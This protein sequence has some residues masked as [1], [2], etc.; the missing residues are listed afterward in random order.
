MAVA[1]AAVEDVSPLK[2]RRFPVQPV[3]VSKSKIEPIDDAD[4]TKLN[5]EVLTEYFNDRLV[6]R[7]AIL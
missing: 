1:V 6:G 3:A 2:R 4:A 5:I 7:L